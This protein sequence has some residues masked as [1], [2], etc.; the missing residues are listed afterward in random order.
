MN[1]CCHAAPGKDMPMPIRPCFQ[2]SSFTEWFPQR[3]VINKLKRAIIVMQAVLWQVVDNSLKEIRKQ[4]FADLDSFWDARNIYRAQLQA[5]QVLHGCSCLHELLTSK[6]CYNCCIAHLCWPFGSTSALCC[7]KSLTGQLL[8][9]AD[10][11]CQGWTI[12]PICKHISCNLKLF[13]AAQQHQWPC[14]CGL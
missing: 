13:C 5:L 2:K 1:I 9:V 7:A 3:L 11:L 10:A 8:Y 14:V 6:L 12:S 4:Y